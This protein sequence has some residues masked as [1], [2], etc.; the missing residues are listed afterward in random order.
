MTRFLSPLP[1]LLA[2][3]AAALAL[4]ACSPKYDWREVRGTG[5]PFSVLL[6][7]K[8][9]TSSRQVNLEGMPVTMT[10]TA[11]EVDDVLFA[12]GAAELPD[13]AASAKALA[14]MKAALARNIGGGIRHESAASAGGA[15]AIDMEAAGTPGGDGQPR[16]LIARLLAVDKHAYQLVVVGKE[17]AVSREAVDTFLRSFK[18]A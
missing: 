8:P 1:S 18:P 17:K 16:L 5:V 14:A 10:M 15:P 12:V 11:A 6:P 9:T 7:A 2:C 4:A 3:I 13:P